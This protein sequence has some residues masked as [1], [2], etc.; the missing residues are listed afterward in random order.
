M[1]FLSLF[2]MATAAGI[3]D[4]ITATINSVTIVNSAIAINGLL[5]EMNVIMFFLLPSIIGGTIFKDFENEMHSVTFSYPFKKWEYLSAKFLSGLTITI[6]VMLCAALGIMLGSVLPGTNSEL[7]GPFI[8]MNYVQS[9]IYYLIP[10]LI[11]YGA[12]V[13][14]VVTFTR[15]VSVGF[16]TVLG[17][18]ILQSFA[19]VLTQDADNKI[20]SA[21][22]DPFGSQANSYYT[23]YWTIY[24]RN[25]N[26]LPFGEI[27]AYNRLL[28]TGIGVLIFGFVYRTFSFHQEAF[29]FNWFRKKEGQAVTK[30]NFGSIMSV[31][32]PKVHLDFSFIENLK[33]SWTL[34]AFD[35]RYI[36]KSWAFIIITILGLLLSLATIT[37]SSEIYGTDTLPVTWQMLEFPG[38]F[39][40]LFT[41]L[42][43]FLYAG[44]LIHR[45]RGSN[46]DQL[47]HSTPAPNWVILFSKFLA[48][49][50]MQAVLLLAVMFLGMG[51]QIFNGYYNFE[52]D[53]YLF[54]LFGI[55]L[56]HVVIWGLLALFVH[57]FFKN[58]YIG[59]FILLVVSIGINFLDTIGIEQMIFKYNQAPGTAYSDMNGYGSSL[60]PYYIYKLY[61]LLLG[62]ALYILALAFFR[63][64]VPDSISERFNVAFKEFTPVLKILFS[65]FMIGFVAMGSWI[66]YV[67]NVKHENLSSKEL[68]KRLAD[69]EKNYGKFEGIPQ[70]RIVDVKVD[71]DLYPESRDFEA[72]G[73]Y[74]LV[75]KTE[76]TIDSIHID[77]GGFVTSFD[78]ET[79][80]E[81]VLEDDTMN[82]DIYQL[83][84]PLSPGDSVIFTFNIKNK[85]NEIFRNNSPIR[86]N[87]TFINNSIFPRVGYNPASELSGEESREKYDLPPKER[88]APPTDSASLRNTYIA[89][90][91][92]WIDFETTISTSPKQIAIAPGYLQKEWTEEGRRY[93]HYKMD[94][95]ML[96]FY[97]YISAEFEIAKDSWNDIP[98]EVY[99]HKDHDY[100]V[101]RMIKGVKRGLEYYT[102]E[103]SPYQHKQVRIIEFPRTGGGFA[104]SFANTIPYS[105]AVGF[106]AAVDD[107]NEDGVDYPFS[108]TA[109]E[110]AHQWWAHQVIGA[111]VQGATVMSE[112]MSE[113]S[114]LKVLEKEYGA[115]KMRIFL[116]DALDSYLTGRTFE[117]TKEKALIYNENQPYIHY[118]KGSLVMYALSD[119][120]GEEKLHEALRAYIDD[121]AFQDPPYTTSLEFLSYLREAT[122]DSLQY[123]LTDMFET[124]TL[125]DNNVK[126]AGF[127]TNADSSYT[128]KLDFYSAKY[129]TS[130]TGKRIYT[131]AEGDSLSLEVEGRRRPIQSLPLADWID[132]GVFGTDEEGK[133]KVLYLKKH[134]IS[135]IENSI[136]ITVD[137]LPLSAGIDPYNKLIDLDSNDN[138]RPLIEQKEE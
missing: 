74:V 67:N 32:L 11:F 2:I 128:V 101:D 125:Y 103:F 109:H 130:E 58:F 40:G 85:P 35:F 108:I 71:L 98:I 80:Y 91:A 50:K 107:E 46:A 88:M 138:R 22:L 42:L 92:D 90:D 52:I 55:N 93:F 53:Q 43:T 133:E 122:P 95:K 124:I 69:W 76:V 6:L 111:N 38:L 10:N 9:F 64:G 48:L 68:E 47:I 8:L 37:V 28:W 1:F 89:Y 118:N 21:M 87:G 24:E 127:S 23:E 94:V 105:E 72:N 70:P 30:K 63:R 65:V 41:N 81:W 33:V 104:Q 49:V 12:I 135:D 61:W 56:I 112:S 31:K 97:S 39:F 59:F 136:E 13:F 114:S 75:N 73:R 57:T 129:R 34:S 25:E 115:E 119:Y 29:S 17:L 45:S 82:Y 20:L 15:N 60:G 99:Y 84:T 106:I 16:I 86:S 14:A 3:F 102:E 19:G 110:V 131:N 54:Q 44:M 96:N 5:N 18:I 51:I 62:A 126:D 120:I 4:G 113:Y 123:L 137:E 100:N 134:K 66:Y 79:D 78:F 121:V 77:H 117:S 83:S 132:V 27:I 116:K 7:L 26:S 36:I